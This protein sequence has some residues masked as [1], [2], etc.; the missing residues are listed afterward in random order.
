MRHRFTWLDPEKEIERVK[1]KTVEEYA[2]SLGTVGCIYS[3]QATL[4]T[5]A[6]TLSYI[7]RLVRTLEKHVV[8]HRGELDH[9][10]QKVHEDCGLSQSM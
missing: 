5:V 2:A 3:E 9:Q 8:M 1:N 7:T 10:L 4:L 6:S